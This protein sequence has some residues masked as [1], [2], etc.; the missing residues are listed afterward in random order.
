M[1]ESKRTPGRC[2]GRYEGCAIIN[3][4]CFSCIAAHNSFDALAARVN[5]DTEATATPDIIEAL[6]AAAA[7]VELSTGNGVTE[8]PPSW[9]ISPSGDYDAEVIA[10]AARAAL[11]KAEG[12]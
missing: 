11:A 1:S 9:A 4:D 6:R 2:P 10:R 12:R 7:F 5:G 8:Q 3:G